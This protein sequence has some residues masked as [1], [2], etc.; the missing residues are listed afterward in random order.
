MERKTII[1]KMVVAILALVIAFVVGYGIGN[2]DGLCSGLRVEKKNLDKEMEA[3]EIIEKEVRE[4]EDIETNCV[5][6]IGGSFIK[7]TGIIYVSGEVVNP[8]HPLYGMYL[9]CIYTGMKI[10]ESGEPLADDEFINTWQID[11]MAARM[12]ES[13]YND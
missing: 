7:G 8:D 2:T 1:M 5:E 4:S 9:E 10:D 6:Y 13:T 11:T 3:L 12:S